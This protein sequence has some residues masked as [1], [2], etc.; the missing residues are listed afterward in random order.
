MES[1]WQQ[2]FGIRGQF[3]RI[4]WTENADGVHA[5]LIGP[6]GNTL[7]GLSGE[8]DRLVRVLTE[9]ALEYANDGSEE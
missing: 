5:D 4:D 7:C 9:C 2:H 1:R 3:F 8:K 6:R